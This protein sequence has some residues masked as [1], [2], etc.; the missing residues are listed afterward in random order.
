VKTSAD[1]AAYYEKI[2]ELCYIR[3]TMPEIIS[4]KEDIDGEEWYLVF[5]DLHKNFYKLKGNA[6]KIWEMLDGE[7]S[8]ESIVEKLSEDNPGERDMVVNDVCRFIS[9]IGKKG[10]IKAAKKRVKASR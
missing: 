2:R 7:K 5:D 1:N 4:R 9:K 3:R 8:V 6:G 10:L